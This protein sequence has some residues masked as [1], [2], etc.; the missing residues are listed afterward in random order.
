MSFVSWINRQE[1]HRL[2]SAQI[3][4]SR[5]QSIVENKMKIECASDVVD[6]WNIPLPITT[7]H[8]PVTI[9]PSIHQVLLIHLDDSQILHTCLQLLRKD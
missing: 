4:T 8:C 1:E 7:L 5:Y 6:E 9:D 2:S 3:L